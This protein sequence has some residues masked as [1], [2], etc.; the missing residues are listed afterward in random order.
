MIHGT[1]Q[2]WER[3]G[4]VVEGS[5]ILTVSADP[6]PEDAQAESSDLSGKTLIP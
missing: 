2:V 1:G 4:I 5:H 3:A 6:V